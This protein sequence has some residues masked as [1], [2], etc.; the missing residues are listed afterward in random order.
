M[1]TTYS[2]ITNAA[3]QRVSKATIVDGKVV[4]ITP[5]SAGDDHN[6]FTSTAPT[7]NN[8]PFASL[9]G[10]NL[11]QITYKAPC[12]LFVEVMAVGAGANA[13]I[14]QGLTNNAMVGR[15][16]TVVTGAAASVSAYISKGKYFYASAVVAP[17]SVKLFITPINNSF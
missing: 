11:G 8:L 13:F 2:Y 3:G 5:I 4:S 15:Q 9:V 1:A 16:Q 7:N 14:G 6:N 17:S 12:D 10:T